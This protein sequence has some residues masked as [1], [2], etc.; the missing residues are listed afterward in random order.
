MT[1][2]EFKCIHGMKRVRVINSIKHYAVQDGDIKHVTK[3]I[4]TK[5][6]VKKFP[7]GA[8]FAKKNT[9]PTQNHCKK[10]FVIAK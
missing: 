3:K 7:R 2:R 10:R 6:D 8:S 1:V 4:T 9:R 5:V